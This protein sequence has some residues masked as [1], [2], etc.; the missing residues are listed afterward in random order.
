MFAGGPP[1]PSPRGRG[2][3]RLN[4]P[5]KLVGSPRSLG[6]D[7]D[8][9]VTDKV[10]LEE[11]HGVS[12]TTNLIWRLV[13]QCENQPSLAIASFWAPHAGLPE[14]MRMQFWTQ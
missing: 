7:A 3:R 2:A 8:F 11:I 5:Y 13:P 1:R 14:P 12:D 9:L 4:A 6:R 10:I